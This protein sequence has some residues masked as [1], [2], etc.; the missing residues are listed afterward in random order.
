[1][2]KVLEDQDFIDC[3]KLLQIAADCRNRSESQWAMSGVL[4]SPNERWKADLRAK[5]CLGVALAIEALV[6]VDY[7]LKEPE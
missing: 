2:A 3:D 5:R 1:M 6:D 4:K 7:D